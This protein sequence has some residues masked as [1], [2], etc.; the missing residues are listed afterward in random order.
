MLR[1][2][3]TLRTRGTPGAA[4]ALLAAVLAGCAGQSAGQPVGDPAGG[5]G[6]FPACEGRP[7]LTAD[8]SL[9]RDEPRY[10]NAMDLVD[11]VRGWA[12]AQR[13]FQELWHDRDHHGWIHV[14]VHG[15]DVDVASL[16]AQVAE[17]FPGQGV[18]V[19]AVPYTLEELRAVSD[20]VDAALRDAGAQITGGSA[21]SV[22]R[23]VV[24]LH[25]VVG[26]PEA[27]AALRAFAGEPL[28][29]DVVPAD[30]IVPEG[31]QQPAGEGWRL[32][33]HEEGAGEA[34]GTGVASS[35]EQLAALWEQSGL[36]GT[37]PAVDW[38]REIA[39]WF[40]AVYGSSCPIRLDDVVVD[41][42]TLHAAIVIPG[43]GPA[44]ACTDDAN[45]HSYVVA[46]ERS[47]LPHGAFV[48]Q[49]GRSDP[50]PGAP[51]ERTVVDVDLSAPGAR[52]TDEQIHPE[53]DAVATPEPA[54][55]DGHAG[56]PPG[57]ARYI[58]HPRPQCDGVVIGPLDGTL[59]R[60]ADHE[61]AWPELP[62]GQEMTLHPLDDETMLVVTPT[63]EYAFVRTHDSTCS[64]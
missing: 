27:E 53:T 3:R 40:G 20:R 56:M 38:Q 22:P 61:P 15:P 50:P 58:W 43:A 39:V 14:G 17:R 60:L 45:P 23:G 62:D 29:V 34:Y 30:Q 59:W 13:G 24:S 25:G 49:L 1:T 47:R 63:I 12:S 31:E 33:G 46:V 41:G 37:A 19:V 64:P 9:Y 4:V 52:A 11:D 21:L 57:G 51:R 8:P 18:V 55:E 10:G 54:V 42:R 28:C 36:P 48:V 5:L 26:S 44:T 7:T 35:D 32:L 2:V 16:Q 6:G